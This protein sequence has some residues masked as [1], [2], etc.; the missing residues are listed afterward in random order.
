MAAGAAVCFFGFVCL[1]GA[2]RE[3]ILQRDLPRHRLSWKD[4]DVPR[5]LPFHYVKRESRAIRISACYDKSGSSEKKSVLLSFCGVVIELLVLFSVWRFC[6]DSGALFEGGKW[7]ER[8]E[9]EV[10]GDCVTTR[11][12]VGFL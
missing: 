2:L 12:L 7:E 5:L 1:R 8:L 11:F 4:D 9:G 3:S 6:C 10:G